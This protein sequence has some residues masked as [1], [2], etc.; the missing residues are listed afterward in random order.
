M[1]QPQQQQANRP[2]QSWYD[3]P[4]E[5]L[6]MEYNPPRDVTQRADFDSMPLPYWYAMPDVHAPAPAMGRPTKCP[7]CGRPMTKCAACEA[8]KVEQK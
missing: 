3:G 2:P 1:T 6:F 7:E 8:G 5:D 4:E